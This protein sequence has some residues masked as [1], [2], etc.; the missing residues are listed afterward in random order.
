M[1]FKTLW[2]ELDVIG[3]LLL[4]AGFS[5]LLVPLTL[6]SSAVGTWNNPSIIAA[7]GELILN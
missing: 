3:V 2:I 1:F 7:I 5:L 6:A 4:V